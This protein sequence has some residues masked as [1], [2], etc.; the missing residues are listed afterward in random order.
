MCTPVN[1]VMF[2]NFLFGKLGNSFNHFPISYKADMPP[3]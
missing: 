1:A 2:G 3:I